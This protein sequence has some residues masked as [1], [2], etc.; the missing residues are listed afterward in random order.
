MFAE[1]GE[2]YS[3]VEAQAEEEGFFEGGFGGE[4]VDLGRRDVLGQDGVQG[5]GG[6]VEVKV[7]GVGEANGAGGGLEHG[8]GVE[9]EAKVGVAMPVFEVV[10]GLVA[11]L[12]LRALIELRALIKLRALPGEVGDFVLGEAGGG[13]G[14]A[15]GLVEVGGLV[16]GGDG[17]GRVAGSLG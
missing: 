15:G 6:K 7:V 5:W 2:A 3:G 11:L 16:V 17:C 9:A 4:V 12:W 14:F 13:E 10:A 1:G 8:V